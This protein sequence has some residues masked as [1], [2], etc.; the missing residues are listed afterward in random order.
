MNPALKE[1]RYF[2][3]ILL[4]NPISYFDGMLSNLSKYNLLWIYFKALSF[5]TFNSNVVTGFIISIGLLIHS[6]VAFVLSLLATTLIFLLCNIL[7]IS[8]QSI[9][10]II[11]TGNFIFTFLAIAGFFLLSSVRSILWSVIACLEY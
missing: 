9:E 5:I 3:I 1:P 11:L 10:G 8:L 7:G 2:S 4:G 6:R